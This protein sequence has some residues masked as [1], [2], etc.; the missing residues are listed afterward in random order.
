M[1]MKLI[2]FSSKLHE[3][4]DLSFYDIPE[5]FMKDCEISPKHEFVMMKGQCSPYMNHYEMIYFMIKSL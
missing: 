1:M 4:N 3:K 5:R 2:R